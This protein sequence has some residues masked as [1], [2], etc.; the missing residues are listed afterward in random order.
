MISER[1]TQAGVRAN[2]LSKALQ[3]A[4]RSPNGCTEA[5]MLA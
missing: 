5:I 2:V 3:N 4:Q 1:L